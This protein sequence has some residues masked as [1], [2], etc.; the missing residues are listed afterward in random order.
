MFTIF[1]GVTRQKSMYKINK[2]WKQNYKK[3][4]NK[5]NLFHCTQ[6]S[7]NTYVKKL[8]KL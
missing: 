2:F 1:E 6:P 7:D 3:G 8:L 4:Y 5:R